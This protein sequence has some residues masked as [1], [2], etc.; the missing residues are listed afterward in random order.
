MRGVT[1]AAAGAGY[2]TVPSCEMLALLIWSVLVSAQ[3]AWRAYKQRKALWLAEQQEQC[4]QQHGGRHQAQPQPL[5]VGLQAS[6]SYLTAGGISCESSAAQLSPTSS[7]VQEMLAPGSSPTHRRR[8]AGA[9]RWE[10]SQSGE[11]SSP[12]SPHGQQEQPA[13][14]KWQRSLGHAT[15]LRSEPSML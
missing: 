13:A 10:A 2:V 14:A 4:R 1:P 15:S 9:L 6:T 3:A 7:Q 12:R 5:Q 11:A 8:A